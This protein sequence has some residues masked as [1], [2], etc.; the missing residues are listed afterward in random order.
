MMRNI[1]QYH[2]YLREKRGCI[3]LELYLLL[4]III[5]QLHIFKTL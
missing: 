5:I 3:G 1:A 2:F 4:C